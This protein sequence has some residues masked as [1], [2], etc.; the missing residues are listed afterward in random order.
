MA[1]EALNDLVTRLI[2]RGKSTGFDTLRDDIAAM[3]IL[4]VENEK[5]LAPVHRLGEYNF[6]KNEIVVTKIPGRDGPQNAELLQ[7]LLHEMHHAILHKRDV[8]A[9]TSV[10]ARSIIFE[11]SFAGKSEEIYVREEL[12]KEFDAEKKA[13]VLIA[14]LAGKIQSVP[15]KYKGINAAEKTQEYRKA[16]EDNY[17]KR[18][19]KVF[20]K[21]TAQAKEQWSAPKKDT[22]IHVEEAPPKPK[23]DPFKET[24]KPK[25]YPRL[26]PRRIRNPNLINS[27]WPGIRNNTIHGAIDQT[28]R[29]RNQRNQFAREGE[30]RRRT[31]EATRRNDQVLR[32]NERIRQQQLARDRERQQQQ[33]RQKEIDRTRQRQN[34]TARRREDA[35]RHMRMRPLHQKVPIWQ[36]RHQPLRHGTSYKG[37]MFANFFKVTPPPSVNRMRL[38]MINNRG[39]SSGFSG[40][41]K[42]AYFYDRD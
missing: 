26:A 36:S 42:P 33:S 30:L 35:V 18:F 34:E 23:T 5:E 14:E 11:N 6:I 32:S 22:E 16:V 31:I 8:L 2:P 41:T 10:S 1:T 28:G 4:V 9:F 27:F 12:G 24:K 37:G 19:V 7:T 29:I 38:H 15:I 17:K 20:R 39:I 3:N 40:G 25:V 13:W 21:Y